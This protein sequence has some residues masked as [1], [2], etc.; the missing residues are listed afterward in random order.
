VEE[1]RLGPESDDKDQKASE[2]IDQGPAQAADAEKDQAAQGGAAQA[3]A[4]EE[5]GP[6]PVAGAEKASEGKQEDSPRDDRRRDDRRRDDRRG[7]GKKRGDRPMTNEEKL[8][9]YKK[10]SEERLLDIK[11]SREAKIGKKRKT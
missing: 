7:G 1:S 2:E 6:P 9:Q 3:G 4:T 5:P 10:Q 11:R 8:R